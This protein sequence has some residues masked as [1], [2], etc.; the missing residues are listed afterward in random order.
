MWKLQELVGHGRKPIY[1]PVTWACQITPSVSEGTVSPAPRPRADAWGY[2]D[3]QWIGFH[4]YAEFRTMPSKSRTQRKPGMTA[5]A[6]AQLVGG[7]GIVRRS[8]TGS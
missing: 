1:H 4:H 2:L 7:L 3:R 6:R 8:A 5:V